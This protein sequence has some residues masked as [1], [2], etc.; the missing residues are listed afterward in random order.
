MLVGENATGDLAVGQEVRMTGPA[1]TQVHVESRINGQLAVYRS[2]DDDDQGNTTAKHKITLTVSNAHPWPIDFEGL[3][4]VDS[5]QEALEHPSTRLGSKD[6]KP[7]WKVRVPANG[8]ATLRYELR[9]IL[10]N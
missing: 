3:L 10:K 2:D 7:L 1:S 5:E 6:G 8:A 9:K 4:I